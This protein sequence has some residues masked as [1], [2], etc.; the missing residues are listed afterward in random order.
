[1]SHKGEPASVLHALLVHSVL[2]R[3]KLYFEWC[4]VNCENLGITKKPYL[5]F[6][7][8]INVQLT[9]CCP[10]LRF[11]FVTNRA[12][13]NLDIFRTS[14]TAYVTLSMNN[15]LL[16]HAFV[17]IVFC[18]RT[19]VNCAFVT[20]PTNTLGQLVPFV[21]H[22]GINCLSYLRV[23]VKNRTGDLYVLSMFFL[24][25]HS[26]QQSCVMFFVVMVNH[27]QL[28]AKHTTLKTGHSCCRVQI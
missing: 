2:L 21:E 3:Y 8:F 11:T 23:S 19:L 20:L 9:M 26:N 15:Q 5:C 25:Y 6:G 13:Q 18:R 7:C 27:G 22:D 10:F 16:I 17:L 14:K 24:S 12:S 28:C 4:L 1:M